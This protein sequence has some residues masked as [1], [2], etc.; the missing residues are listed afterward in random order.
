M[1]NSPLVKGFILNSEMRP[2]PN[3]EPMIMIATGTGISHFI[4]FSQE[5]EFLKNKQKCVLYFGCKN[6]DEDFIY[7][8]E[9]ENFERNLNIRLRIAFSRA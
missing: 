5:W 7:R 4:A 9:I 8:N 3:N 1:Y 6:E 2:P